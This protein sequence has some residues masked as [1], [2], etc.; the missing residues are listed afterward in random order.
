MAIPTSAVSSIGSVASLALSRDNALS[1]FNKEE[2]RNALGR[3]AFFNCLG[4]IRDRSFENQRYRASGQYLIFAAITLWNSVYLER[5]VAAPARKSPGR[6]RGRF[7]PLRQPAPVLT[8][9]S[10][11]FVGAWGA[12]ARRH[13]EAA[14]DSIKTQVGSG[15]V[16]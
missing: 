7:G 3:A 1:T 16:V 11:T 14:H 5:S 2:A 10:K 6:A 4:E 12:V 13:I 8:E 9:V 15:T